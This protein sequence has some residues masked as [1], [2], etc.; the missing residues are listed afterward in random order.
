[1]PFLLFRPWIAACRTCAS[2]S[3]GAFGRSVFLKS[4]LSRQRVHF[5]CANGRNSMDGLFRLFHFIADLGLVVSFPYSPV[6]ARPVFATLRLSSPATAMMKPM[7][8]RWRFLRSRFRLQGCIPACSSAHSLGDQFALLVLQKVVGDCYIEPRLFL[9][10]RFFD[11]LE[12]RLELKCPFA[13]KVKAV[14]VV[15][16]DLFICGRAVDCA[17]RPSCAGLFRESVVYRCFLQRPGSAYFYAVES[18]FAD[19]FPHTCGR[20]PSISALWETDS[21]VGS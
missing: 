8:N 1:M 17:C 19:E 10:F 4:M 18:S 20:E 15:C 13:F 16:W 9:A 2:C 12:R 11:G 21:M 14:Q 3:K 6:V 5:G 7:R